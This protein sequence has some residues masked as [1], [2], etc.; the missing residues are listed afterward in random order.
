MKHYSDR[1][2][3]TGT[4]GL[5]AVDKKGNEVLFLDPES[6]NVIAS[7]KGFALRVHELLISEDHT[8]AFVP[9]YGDGIHG[10]NPNPGH[11]IAVI[12]LIQK[13]HIGDFS[14][15]VA[16]AATVAKVLLL[17]GIAE[18]SQLGQEQAVEKHSGRKSAFVKVSC[19]PVTGY[20]LRFRNCDR[21]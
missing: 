19:S 4:S 14:V 10:N 6:Y 3:T 21:E 8:R 7:I 12:D 2:F 5:I 20:L 1:N 16:V 15:V 13:R 9:I 17:V 11:L 18:Q